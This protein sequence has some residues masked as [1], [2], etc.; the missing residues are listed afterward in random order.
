MRLSCDYVNL[1]TKL[2]N[3]ELPNFV[4]LLADI[5]VLLFLAMNVGTATRFV[6]TVV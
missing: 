2:V 5:V 3:V 6:Y 4:V 1:Y